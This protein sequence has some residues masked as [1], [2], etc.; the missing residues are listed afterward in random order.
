MKWTKGVP[1]K[2]GLYV[3]RFVN[4]TTQVI[5]CEEGL[6]MFYDEEED[7][8]YEVSGYILAYIPIPEYEGGE[9]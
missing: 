6:C 7:T 4:G 8:R 2:D 1:S 9:R 3:A 5:S